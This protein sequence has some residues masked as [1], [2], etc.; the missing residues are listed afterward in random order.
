VTVHGETQNTEVQKET[1]SAVW[2]HLFFWELNLAP[3]ESDE[4]KIKIEV[5]DQGDL[6]TGDV[7]IG[8][9]AALRISHITTR[10]NNDL[11]IENS[12]RV[13]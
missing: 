2:D 9:C 11:I 3:E 1:T 5:K 7:L 10:N 4:L 12:C 13:V 6:V 8:S